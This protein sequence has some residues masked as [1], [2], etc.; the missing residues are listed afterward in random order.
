MSPVIDGVIEKFDDIAL[1]W[2]DFQPDDIYKFN[3]DCVRP[4]SDRL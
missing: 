4:N 3:R 2:K 1:D